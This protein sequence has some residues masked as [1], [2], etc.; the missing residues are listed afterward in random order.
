[1]TVCLTIV[2]AYYNWSASFSKGFSQYL[3][4]K[5]ATRLPEGNI[6]HILDGG[7]RI[8]MKETPKCL[9]ELQNL[10]NA[11]SRGF[12]VCRSKPLARLKQFSYRTVIHS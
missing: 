1:L 5:A 4:L 11:I 10:C 2:L 3:V 8:M 9:R 12:R 6:A 7:L